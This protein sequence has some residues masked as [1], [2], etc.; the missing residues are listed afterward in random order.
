MSEYQVLVV[1]DSVFMRKIIS[2]LISEHPKYHVAGTA[3]N[4]RD[5]VE[6]TKKLKPDI[7]T[8]DI[9]MPEM[10]GLEALKIIMREQPTPVIM[11]S[12]LTQAGADETIK[13]L[14]WGAVDFLKKPSGSISFDLAKI[15][16]DLFEKMEIAVRCNVGRKA[17]VSLKPST[18][19]SAQQPSVSPAPVYTAAKSGFDHIVAIGTSTGGPR[20]LHTVISSIPKEFPAPILIV[21]HMPPK[22]TASL[23]NRLNAHSAIEVIEA[24]DGMMIESGKAYLAKGGHQMSVQEKSDREY[25]IRV[26]DDALYSGH[27][28]SVDFLFESIAKLKKVKKT[29]VL[30]TGMG[31]D[32]AKGMLALRNSGAE[33][34]IAEA[35]ETCVV[36][37]MPK[38]AVELKCVTDVLPQHKIAG[39]LVQAVMK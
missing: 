11:L 15:K 12:S 20:A 18:S 2:D 39:K 31:S 35:E 38:S 28:P 23:A 29:V 6:L 26:T 36:Y 37:G 4:G 5:A 13:A 8:M 9:E 16:N 21:Q 17:P 7:I 19:S 24:T 22:F 1:D 3:K 32:G 34:T 27:R 33:I 10:N 30:M 14:E 25:R